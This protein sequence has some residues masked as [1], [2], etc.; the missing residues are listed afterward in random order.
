LILYDEN[1]NFLAISNE[2]VSFLGYENIDEFI[3]LNSDFAD[4]LVAKEGKIYKF[5]N[6]SWIDFILYSGAPNK[7]AIIKLKDGSE[8]D[9][10]LTVKEL[11]LTRDI[12]GLEKCFAVRII[13]DEFV[14]IASKVNKNMKFE[15]NKNVALSNLLNEPSVAKSPDLNQTTP[16]A[17]IVLKENQ[18][19]QEQEQKPLLDFPS[20]EE[21]KKS[22]ALIEEDDSLYDKPSETKEEEKL[23]FDYP[24]TDELDNGIENQV[25]DNQEILLDFTQNKDKEQSDDVDVDVDLSFLNSSGNEVSKESNP[26][27]IPNE[28]SNEESSSLDF[29]KANSEQT[30]VQEASNLD[31]IKAN[32]SQTAKQEASNL[33]FIKANSSQTADQD[34]SNLEFIKANSNKGSEEEASNLDFIKANSKQASNQEESNLDFI[35][36]SSNVEQ[37]TEESSLDFI[38]NSQSTPSQAD[39]QNKK[40][41]EPSL[42]FLKNMQ[43][44][45]SDKEKVIEQIKN[46]IQEIDESKPKDEKNGDIKIVE[47]SAFIRKVFDEEGL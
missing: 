10:K 26:A 4:L 19:V 7:S 47:S 46:D 20:S 21:L 9:I 31:F 44:E 17:D 40:S 39:L 6:F 32:S 15:V 37:S 41:D 1:Y 33:D 29:L 8:I 28:S 34:A 25:D 11:T 42:D 18:K 23:T 24:H 2:T 5:K 16:T 36:S 27:I 38:K 22:P 3:S 43:E 30:E 12:D 13:S 14:K 35:K 45:Q